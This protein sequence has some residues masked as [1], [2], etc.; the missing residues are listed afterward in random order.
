MKG[1]GTPYSQ[2]RL[3]PSLEPTPSHSKK[4]YQQREFLLP[5]NGYNAATAY[6]EDAWA[7]LEKAIPER[8]C[9]VAVLLKLR[10]PA[11]VHQL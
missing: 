11:G 1:K 3:F 5:A 4:F 9:H 10:L 6:R 2:Q 8:V 7:V